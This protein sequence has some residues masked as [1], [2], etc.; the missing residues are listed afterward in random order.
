[1]SKEDIPGVSA[2]YKV[3]NQSLE[4]Y[5]PS[6]M[7]SV[8]SLSAE[9]FSVH[10]QNPS[11]FAALLPTLK[12]PSCISLCRASSAARE[13]C[14]QGTNH[15]W[16]LLQRSGGVQHNQEPQRTQHRVS[17]KEGW[18]HDKLLSYQK[19]CGHF[20]VDIRIRYTSLYRAL[21]KRSLIFCCL[22]QQPNNT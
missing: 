16:A 10:E 18:S 4:P 17:Y 11:A 1:M 14:A 12:L 8:A 20:S 9:S 22:H 5:L 7:S 6:W 13:T 2:P 21:F 15:K 3:Q 19:R